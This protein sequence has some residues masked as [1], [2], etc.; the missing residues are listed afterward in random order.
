MKEDKI[1]KLLQSGKFTI[2]YW[3]NGEATLYKGKWD[4]NKEYIKNDYKTMNKSIIEISNYN[5]GYCPEIVRLLT[6]AL[7]GI[8]DSI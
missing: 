7:N 8:S 5:N 2:V 3:D 6:K 1:L 4:Y